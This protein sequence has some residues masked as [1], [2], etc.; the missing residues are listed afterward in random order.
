M[1][2]DDA[3]PTFIVLGTFTNE[4]R[5]QIASSPDRLDVGR[6]VL[7]RV[8]GSLKAFYLTMGEYDFI[9]V[10]EAPDAELVATYVLGMSATG[11]VRTVTLQ[12]F[13]EA[14]YRKIIKGTAD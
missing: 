2:G 11:H 4:G 8:G 7:A 12:A 3:M 5:R 1:K 10:L 6:N 13:P 9:S 14:E